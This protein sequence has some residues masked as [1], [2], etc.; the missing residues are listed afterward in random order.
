MYYKGR[1]KGL[2]PAETRTFLARADHPTGPFAKSLLNPVIDSGHEVCVWPHGRGIAAMISPCGPQGSTIQFSADG[3]RF[4]RVASI[5]PGPPSA[6]GPFRA[7]HYAD[8]WGPG[9]TWGLCQDISSEDRP[10]LLRFD[11]RLEAEV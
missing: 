10:F 7:D 11:C 2:S 5:R 8:G 1:Q 3:L 6:P 4:E 9:I